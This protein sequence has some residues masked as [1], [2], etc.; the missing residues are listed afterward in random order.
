MSWSKCFNVAALTPAVLSAALAFISPAAAGIND[1]LVAFY[2]FEG[3]AADSSGNANHGTP[4]GTPGYTAG[5][6]DQAIVLDG[7]ND[8]VELPGNLWTT[9]FSTSFWVRTTA[10]AP[11]GQVWYQ[12]L[13]LVD[14][15]VCGSPVGGD[16]GIAMIDG[17]KVITYDAK[18]TTSINDGTYHAIIVT[19]STVDDTVKMYIDG[20]LETAYQLVPTTLTG[21]PW[22]GVGN[23]PCD[24]TFNRLY[25]PGEIDELRFYDRVLDAAEIA[26]LS[27]NTNVD[28]P[29]VET[30]RTAFTS[31]FPNPT[32]GG[33][34]VSFTL[35]EPLDT[36]LEVFDL[37]GARVRTLASG[38][39]PAG[40][41]TLEWNGDDERG[42]AVRP[43]V[44]LIGFSAG[45]VVSLHKLVRIR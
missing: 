15:E 22:I 45:G 36:R 31:A 9:A 30:G 32:R 14:G 24:V 41:H 1:G 39:W 44:Y 38:L 25:F 34:T 6:A 26:E 42:Q 13:G 43:G 8:F 33:A 10:I 40:S 4:F 35:A 11:S 5:H 28:V 16:F 2:R 21:M 20:G 37:R 12:G 7:V 3:N 17:G 29:A 27:G 19:R 23:N 18:T